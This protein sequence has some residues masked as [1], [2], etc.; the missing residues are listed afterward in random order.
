MIPTARIERFALSS[1]F[2]I[3]RG[4]KTEAVVVVCELA[5]HRS[6]GAAT[7][8]G[9]ALPYARYGETP[10]AVRAQIEGYRGPLERAALIDA[11]P[12][13]AARNAIDLAL[14]DLEAK[15]AGEPAWRLAGL[16]PPAPL[17]VLYTL[18]I[19]TPDE[20]RALAATHRARPWLK[21]K[22]GAGAEGD[23]ARVRA[24]RDGAP[25]AR[26]V[27]DANEGWS[28]DDL[29]RLAP[30]LAALGVELI[31][32]P[33]PS[34]EDAALVGYAG[35]VPL[36]ADEAFHGGPAEVAGLV[37][38]YTAINVKL[39]KAGGLTTAI[40]C[41]AAARRAGLKVMVG[42]MV[43]TSLAVAPAAL[44]AAGADWADLDA[45]L[46]LAADRAPGLRFD[47]SILHPPPPALWG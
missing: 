9:E 14:F 15:R 40:A 36:C 24:A 18:P 38:R 22:L 13:G 26:F 10:E 30:A 35:P 20:T 19:R 11:L 43:A 27:V 5:D 4:S 7:G 34:A 46:Y 33:L 23:L 42:S 17:E 31:E 29:A 41:V 25:D 21:L 39:D 1:P 32:Q 37:G 2:T 3:A 16:P 12:A 28:I 8:R 47:G 45:P 44:L 6:D